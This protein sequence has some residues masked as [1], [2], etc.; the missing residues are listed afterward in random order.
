MARK[1]KV[2]TS[3]I[4]AYVRPESRKFVFEE[5]ARLQTP[6]GASGYVEDLITAAR[7]RAGLKKDL[8][9]DRLKE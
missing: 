8:R 9:G 5:A 4:Y 3:T 1:C 6:G 7:K 2:L